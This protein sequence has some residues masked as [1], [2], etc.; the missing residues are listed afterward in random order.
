MTARVQLEDLLRSRGFG[1]TLPTP[2]PAATEVTCPRTLLRHGAP[3]GRIVELV[4]DPS[5]AAAPSSGLASLACRLAARATGRAGSGR[6]GWLD[7]SNRFDPL[8]AARAGVVLDRLLWVR[9]D[10][11]WTP[12]RDQAADAGRF[13]PLTT[14]TGERPTGARGAAPNQ[15]GDAARLARL[16]R[17]FEALSLLVHCGDFE[18]LVL[19]LSA[20]PMA[21]LR[22][23]E[24]SG[25]LR[26]LRG[27]ERVRRTAVVVLAPAPLAGSCGS[28]VVGVCRSESRWRQRGRSWLNGLLVQARVLSS[29]RSEE[30]SIRTTI[31]LLVPLELRP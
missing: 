19:D 31:P 14:K 8:S 6:V 11:P 28:L 18:L 4:P 24:R 17:F 10:V 2:F 13:S 29:R 9:G 30:Y 23:L 20:W 22:R 27:V 12:Q 3:A 21:D 1:A 15:S 26:L 7:P 5:A 25:W 16:A